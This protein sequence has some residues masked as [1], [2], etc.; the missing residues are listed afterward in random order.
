[1]ITLTRVL[2]DTCDSTGCSRREHCGSLSLWFTTNYLAFSKKKGSRQTCYVALSCRATLFRCCLWNREMTESVFLRRNSFTSKPSTQCLPIPSC[3]SAH[4]SSELC[5][6][7][8]PFTFHTSL[9]LYS[10]QNTNQ[11]LWITVKIVT[12]W[13][14]FSL[15]ELFLTLS[16][17]KA[18]VQK[19]GWK[20]HAQDVFSFH[21]WRAFL[22]VGVFLCLWKT[23]YLQN[24]FNYLKRRSNSQPEV[25]FFS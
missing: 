1:M 15:L 11:E 5:W 25:P 6:R 3:T 13:P 18:K 9:V 19:A 16:N 24:C 14:P 4:P 21:N 10:L 22:C 20:T 7:P 23:G 12:V 17:G 8:Q 2:K